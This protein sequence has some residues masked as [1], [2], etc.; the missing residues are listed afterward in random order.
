MLTRTSARGLRQMLS[1]PPHPRIESLTKAT[2]EM[3]IRVLRLSRVED[4]VVTPLSDLEPTE[5]DAIFQGCR[6]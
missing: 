6:C 1:T 2:L 3:L 4:V 5:A